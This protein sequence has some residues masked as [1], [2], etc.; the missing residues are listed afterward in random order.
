MWELRAVQKTISKGSSTGKTLKNLVPILVALAITIGNAALAGI[1][2]AVT[3]WLRERGF[4]VF[5]LALAP[6]WPPAYGIALYELQQLQKEKQRRSSIQKIMPMRR[7]NRIAASER[8]SAV[9][10][11]V[12]ATKL[13]LLRNEQQ[14]RDPSASLVLGS[15]VSLAFLEQFVRES[16]VD[17]TMTA[18]DVVNAH[19]K[20]HTKEVGQDG[21]G[22]F[23][24]LIGD[25]KDDNGQRWCDTPTHMLSYSWSYS[26]MMIVDA[27]SKFEC[28]HPPS[29]GQCNYY[30]VDQFALN[31]HEFAKDCTQQEVEDMM[32]ATLKESIRVPAQMICLLHPWEVRLD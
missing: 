7:K 11:T 28:E 10:D 16:G 24:G 12:A 1:T 15:G 32:L 20:P 21:S 3:P 5:F 14:R 26:V 18:N 2:I 4:M 25:G 27:L 17:A 22:A 30:F 6:I 19:V 29:K 8:T 23:V 31:Q 9:A 13:A